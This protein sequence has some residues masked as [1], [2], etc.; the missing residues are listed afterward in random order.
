MPNTQPQIQDPV[1]A[2]HL[3]KIEGKMD[4]MRTSNDNL[5]KQLESVIGE[6]REV[7][8]TA[9]S[10]SSHDESI[11]RLWSDLEKRESKLEDRLTPLEQRCA[12]NDAKISKI[13][14]FSAGVSS[15]SSILLGLIL[16]VVGT[17]MRKSE[18]VESRVD[19]IE[20]HM[21]AD[22]QRPYHPR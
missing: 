22:P 6:L 12:H 18:M 17:E 1:V 3:A 7:S 21:A 4:A 13:F 2:I 14:W 20:L 8:K 15:V 10:Y 19:R 16:W 5:A 11:R 9:S